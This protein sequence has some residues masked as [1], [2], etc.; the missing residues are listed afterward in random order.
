M[1]VTGRSIDPGTYEWRSKKLLRDI[2]AD[3]AL[4]RHLGVFMSLRNIGNALED[5]K[6]YGPNT[7]AIARFRQR[8][9]YG[10]AWVFGMKGTF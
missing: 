6:R 2:Y 3:Y 10:S 4:T 9:D 8:Q 7:P 5:L 1:E